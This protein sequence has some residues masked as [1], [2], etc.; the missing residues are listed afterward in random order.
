MFDIVYRRLSLNQLV[1]LQ[2]FAA[3]HSS[4]R[5]LEVYDYPA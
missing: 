4:W 1:R 3:D 2:Q 5:S